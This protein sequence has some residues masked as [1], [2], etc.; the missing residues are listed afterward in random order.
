L[1]DR[2][3]FVLAIGALLGALTAVPLTVGAQVWDPAVAVS[4]YSAALNTHDLPAALAL[5]D[6]YGSATD[7]AG[8]HFEGR[9]GLTDFLVS[10]GFDS[11]DARITT[12]GLH[13][14]G[15][16]AVWT[17]RCSCATGSTEVRL[18]LNHDKISVFAVM[19][20]PAAPQPRSSPGWLP[21]LA[22]LGLVAGALA[23]LFGLWRGR[24]ACPAPRQTQ[25]H[26][27]A[28][29]ALSRDQTATRGRRTSPG[30]ES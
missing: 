19:A 5:F 22:G 7:A 11:P 6:Q 1:V 28:A 20:Q 24:P 3:R 15:N 18:V 17:Y 12:E 27:L 13:V 4:A 10:S 2:C 9:A 14:V 16:R 25:G 26:L 29:L 30:S 8:H 23:G 21:W